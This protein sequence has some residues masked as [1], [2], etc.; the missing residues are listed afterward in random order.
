MEMY[1]TPSSHRKYLCCIQDIY[2]KEFL[3]L[4]FELRIL[5]KGCG[6][7]FFFFQIFNIKENQIKKKKKQNALTLQML[8]EVYNLLFYYF[9]YLRNLKWVKMMALLYIVHK[10][11]DKPFNTLI[12]LQKVYMI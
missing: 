1:A 4:I 11:I 9:Y 2:R 10:R 7:F 6:I 5:S 8:Y 12:L 3:L